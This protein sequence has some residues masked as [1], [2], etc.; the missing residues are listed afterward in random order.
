MSR[1]VFIILIFESRVMPSKNRILLSLGTNLGN[2]ESTLQNVVNVLKKSD[3]LSEVEVSKYYQ[4]EPV[5]YIEQPDFLNIAFSAN[6]N[7]D[8]FQ[9]IYLLKSIEYLFGRKKR[10]KWH[11]REI[12]I[13]II[14]FGDTILI[15]EQL[16]IPHKAMHL[17]RFVLL[18]AL[19]ISPEMLHPLFDK[20]IKQLLEECNDDA[21]VEIYR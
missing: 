1:Y 14:L 6:T 12:D 16:T 3:F 9:L 21:I 10:Q 13:D 4:T 20:S 7:I 18:P 15:S 2:R 19:D 17:R 5:G 8:L 11:Q